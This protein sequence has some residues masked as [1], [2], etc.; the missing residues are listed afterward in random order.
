MKP[1]SQPSICCAC[2]RTQAF[3]EFNADG[4]TFA[5]LRLGTAL[6][7]AAS[8]GNVTEV[9]ALLAANSDTTSRTEN[10]DSSTLTALR[11]AVEKG[12]AATARVLLQHRSRAKGWTGWLDQS[13]LVN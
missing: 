7:V 10:S 8:Q 5:H 4:F 11:S 2:F 3:T 1:I 12:K 9:L 6:E 13:L